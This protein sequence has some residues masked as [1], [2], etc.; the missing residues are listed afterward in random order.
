MSSEGSRKA[1]ARRIRVLRIIAR[2]NIGGPALHATLLTEGL[3]P[4]RYECVLACGDLEPGEGDY[5]GLH[6]QNVSSLVNIAGLGRQIRGFKDL[7]ALRQLVRLMREFKP[8][9]VHTHTAKAGTLGRIAAYFTSV[10]IVI[11]T[12]HGHVFHGYFSRFTTRIFIGIERWLATI[13][14]CLL[15]VS[16]TVRAELLE[17]GIGTPEQLAVV[18]LGLE[19]ERF[20]RCSERK[21]ELRRELG[22]TSATP[23]VGIVARLVPIKAHDTFL[24]AAAIAARGSASARFVVVGDGECRADLEKLTKE[25]GISDVVHFLGWRADL[26]RIY[27]DLDVV[28]LTSENEGSPVSLIE[29][30]TAQCAIVATRVG[31]VPDLIEDR[32]T[33]LLVPPGNPEAFARALEELLADPLL[34][35]S[36]GA[37]AR[38]QAYPAFS[39]SRLINDIDRLYC[40]LLAANVKPV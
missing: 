22:I 23:L 39:A 31:G 40:S 2:L 13:S 12:Y 10:P 7:S 37:A 35:R 27:A 30:M 32:V 34:Q 5:L 21:G 36:L 1:A 15:A 24:R 17:L 6:F 8:D 3:D 20:R 33:G 28:A 19:L 16:P 26:D 29:A 11:H 14:S 4:A 25:L 9:I 18:P 38:L